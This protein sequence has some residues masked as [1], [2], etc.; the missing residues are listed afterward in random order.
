MNKGASIPEFCPGG[1][2]PAASKSKVQDE[3]KNGPSGRENEITNES[4]DA[5]IKKR[6]LPG[7]GDS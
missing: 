3:E 6:L 7:I 4:S 2:P 5:D 1:V